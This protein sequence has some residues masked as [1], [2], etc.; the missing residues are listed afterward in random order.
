MSN[1][2]C[3]ALGGERLIYCQRKILRAT[4]K[5]TRPQLAR[6]ATAT[7]TDFIGA[8]S[9]ITAR[10][11]SF[12][13]V[14]GSALIAGCKKSGNLAYEKKVPDSSH[15]GSMTRFI[16]P[17]TPSIVLGRDA[18]SNPTPAKDSDPIR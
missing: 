11:A 8:P 6:T 15:I 18:T 13:A 17:E 3:R 16:I 4:A 2:S 9:F 12:R 14:S 5:L 10:R 7:Q 1:R